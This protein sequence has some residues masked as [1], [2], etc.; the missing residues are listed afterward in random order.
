[1]PGREY[2]IEDL[3]YGLML[4]SG[5][6]TANALAKAGAGGDRAKAVRMMNAQARRLGA[7]DTNA[8]N[9][10]YRDAEALLDWGFANA[11]AANP[12]GVL[13]EPSSPAATTSDD[14][15]FAATSIRP[16]RSERFVRPATRPRRRLRR[17]WPIRSA[18]SRWRFRR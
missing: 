14:R 16:S 18:S 12:V 6:H 1:M 11:A 13:V 8:V 2:L 17:D 3:W 7:F 4:R 15:S 5:N 10:T 9:P